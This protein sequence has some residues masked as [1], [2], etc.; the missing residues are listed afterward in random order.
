MY[1]DD[2]KQFAKNETRIKKPNKGSENIQSRH[3]DGIRHSEM[4]HATIKEWETT[5][6]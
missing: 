6:D 3:R 1:I 2:I 4:R 5:H